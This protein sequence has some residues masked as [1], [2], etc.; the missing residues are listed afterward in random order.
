MLAEALITHGVA[1]SRLHHPEKARV[2]LRQAADVAEQAGDIESAGVAALTLIEEL[3][4]DFSNDDERTTIERANVLLEK[5]QNMALVKRLAIASLRTVRT[6]LG[7]PDWTNFSLRDAVR[8]YEAH[9]IKLALEETGGLVTRATPLLGFKHHQSLISVINARHHDLLAT[10]SPVIKRKHSLLLHSKRRSDD[11]SVRP[12][13]PFSILHVE[14]NQV[15]A[16]MVKETL[17][18]EGWDI[19][20][21]VDGTIALEKIESDA[22]YDLLLLDSDLPGVN[23]LDLLRAARRFAHRRLTPIVLLSAQT[24][25]REALDAGANAVLHKPEGVRVLAKTIARFLEVQCFEDK[26]VS[27][28]GSDG[29]DLD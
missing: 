5:T 10:R 23:G 28:E 4:Q 25:E 24:I 29:P 20:T 17:E 27:E 14:D 6:I 8:S 3:G 11:S 19:E 21:C 18:A 9:W 2:A 15:V 12:V 26:K 1:L 7:P 13:S 22:H 16:I